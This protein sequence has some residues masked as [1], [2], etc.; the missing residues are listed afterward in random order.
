VNNIILLTDSLLSLKKSKLLKQLDTSH[1]GE[2]TDRE[3]ISHD[4]QGQGCG[5]G[6]DSMDAEY[7]AFQVNDNTSHLSF[8][9]LSI[10]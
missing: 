5:S 7:A 6:A 10:E 8:L 9:P 4:D 3:H 1:D 2:E